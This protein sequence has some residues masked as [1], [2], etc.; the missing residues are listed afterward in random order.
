MAIFP[1]WTNSIPAF[2][3]L[4][5][6]FG[7]VAVVSGFWVYATPKFWEAGY[8]PE[9][10][11][12]YSH[13]LHAQQLGIDCRYCHTNVEKSRIANVPSTN[14]CM[15]CHTIVDAQRGYLKKATAVEGESVHF[16]SA[17]LQALRS[18]AASGDPAPWKRIHKLPDY[19]QFNHAAHLQ[20][21]VSCFSC[22][23]RIDQM[24]IV[25]QQN[26][27]SMK[28]CLDCHRSPAHNLIDKTQGRVTDLA[29]VQEQLNQD[30]YAT[31]SGSLLAEKLSD[32]SR[33][34]PPT[35]CSACHY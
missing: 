22:H 29:W 32:S 17:A 27:L 7:V 8:Q 9:Q 4:S 28:W 18:Y 21:G 10:P 33:G 2:A 12:S 13:Q 5:A 35:H 14:T 31:S 24:A 16:K 6:A 23:G 11:I 3:F 20:A 1:K 15:N 25:Y 26:P 34:A 30:G 19:V